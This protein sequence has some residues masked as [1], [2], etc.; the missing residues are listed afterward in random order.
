[1]ADPGPQLQK[2]LDFRKSLEETRQVL[3]RV[4]ADEKEFKAEVDRHLRA[5]AKGELP[6]ADAPR[7]A[8]VLCRSSTSQEVTKAKAEAQ[9]AVERAEAH[10]KH[11]E[12]QAAR[13]DKLALDSR[14]AGGRRG[15]GGPCRRGA[16]DLRQGP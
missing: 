13:A 11:A 8:M 7:E 6:K 12:A 5:F 14:R 15:A 9:A 4:F 3:Y 2:V 16:P 1:M 10:Q